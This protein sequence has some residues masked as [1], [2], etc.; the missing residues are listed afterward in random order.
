MSETPHTD[1][2]PTGPAS[3][4]DDANLASPP[5]EV[6]IDYGD[7]SSA[8]REERICE[9]VIAGDGGDYSW[10]F[11]D[12][13]G[14]A[15]REAARLTEMLHQVVATSPTCPDS[16]ACKSCPCA[17][18]DDV[19]F[20]GERL[21]AD[22]GAKDRRIAQLVRQVDRFVEDGHA[23]ALA[24]VTEPNKVPYDVEIE[25]AFNRV[26]EARSV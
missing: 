12:D 25:A 20:P 17:D 18:E 16:E 23:L 19:C 26:M 22:G 2:A 13:E 4:S 24:L 11:W 14:Q 9:V 5:V 7:F 8:D 1:P 15:Q 6:R 3:R 10:G 21:R